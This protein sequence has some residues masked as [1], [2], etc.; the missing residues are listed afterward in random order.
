[1]ILFSLLTQIIEQIQ[2]VVVEIAEKCVSSAGYTPVVI[3]KCL[4]GEA[5]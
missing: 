1:M 2:Q 3:S 5:R 4:T